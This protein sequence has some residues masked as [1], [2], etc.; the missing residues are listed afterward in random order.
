MK[1][2]VPSHPQERLLFSVF[3]DYSHSSAGE[4]LNS[5]N[6]GKGSGNIV[7]ETVKV[8]WLQKEIHGFYETLG[9]EY[10]LKPLKNNCFH[11]LYM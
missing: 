8:I 6:R 7:H 1:V 11:V 3:F 5:W 10:D 9:G 2:S 4:L